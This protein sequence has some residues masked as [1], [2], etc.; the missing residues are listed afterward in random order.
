MSEPSATAATPA[1][2]TTNRATPR[3]RRLVAKIGRV[4][5]ACAL[6]LLLAEVAVR[7]VAPQELSGTWRVVAPRGYPINK[8]GGASRHQG[9]WGDVSYR[10]NA[11]H[12]RGGPLGDAKAR[13]LCLGD[14]YTFGWG[15]D[16][17]DTFVARLQK[18]AD[19]RFGAGAFE[20]ENGG[21]GG[22]GTAAAVAFLE[23]FGETI[24][25]RA[26][27]MFLNSWDVGRSLYGGPFVL[28]EKTGEAAP[29]AVPAPIGSFARGLS[30]L[31]LYQWLLEHSHLVQF[32]RMTY[33]KRQSAQRLDAVAEERDAK[34]GDG[35]A[36]GRLPPEAAAKR[37]AYAVAMGRA[38]FLRAKRWCDAHDAALFVVT[39]GRAET[40]TP[41][42]WT[43][44]GDLEATL[45]FKKT[46]AAFFAE[47]AIGYDDIAGDVAALRGGRPESDFEIKGD[48]HPSAEGARLIA[49]CAW[50]RLAPRLAALR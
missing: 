48:G 30:S 46:A 41:D 5:A 43:P 16:E 14:S 33:V 1:A 24:R 20:F 36:T 45:A 49:E 21:C 4:L 2:P 32:A 50:K 15:L 13:A 3:R 23:D 29:R 35:G 28:D 25:P 10:F 18:S 26:V 39:T 11:E 37:D 12:L 42:G 22:W 6:T 44:S 19:A 40:T 34:I 8:A 9:P 47:H 38:L 31:G 7:I 27:V 17:P